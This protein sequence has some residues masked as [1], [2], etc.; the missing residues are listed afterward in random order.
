MKSSFKILVF[1]LSVCVFIN[2]EAQEQT[3][4]S[5]KTAYQFRKTHPCPSTGQIQKSCKGWVINHIVPLCYGG[6]DSVDNM[7]WEEKVS[8]YK[9]DV[10]ERKICKMGKVK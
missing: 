4:R 3:A 8:S 1:I 5:G 9:R 7:E 2:A 6:I 10:F